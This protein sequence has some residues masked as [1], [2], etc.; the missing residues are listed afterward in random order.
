[1]NLPEKYIQ[2]LLVRFTYH[3]VSMAGYETTPKAV[4]SILLDQH[5]PENTDNET[6]LIID[7][8]RYAMELIIRKAINHDA[9]TFPLLFELHH[10]LLKDIDP[11]RGQFKTK[12]NKIKGNTFIPASPE[13]TPILM[14]QSIDD[15]NEKVTADTSPS[16]LIGLVSLFAVV[17]EHI[18]PFERGNGMLARLAMNFLLMKEEIVPWIVTVDDAAFY[19]KLLHKQNVEGLTHFA[20]KMI[21]EEEMRKKTF[22]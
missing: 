5:H 14:K 4:I 1:M 6:F 17:F 9:L 11:N 18:Q 21:H 13:E 8:H 10:R 15:I 3:S 12:P 19:Q 2:D 20:E 22:E 16:D 7:N